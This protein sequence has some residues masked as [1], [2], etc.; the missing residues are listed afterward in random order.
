MKEFIFILFCTVT[1]LPLTILLHELG[2]FFTALLFQARNIKVKVGFGN[3]IGTMKM[4][5]YSISF[6][7]LPFIGSTFYELA[8][9]ND[10]KQVIISASG[11]ILN[12]IIAFGLILQ[13]F[14][15]DP[16]FITLWFQWFII[17]NFFMFIMNLIPFK[18]G[19]Y[20]SDGWI[21]LNAIRK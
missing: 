19:S 13:G 20:Y 15:N 18:L 2:H 8:Q 1:I 7:Y 14:G 21:V 16:S 10:F 3:K 5:E 17:Y 11:P 12:G 4:K 6:H 9:P